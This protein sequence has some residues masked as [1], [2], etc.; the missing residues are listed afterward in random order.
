MLQKRGA[1]QTR[2]GLSACNYCW[3]KPSSRPN[4]FQSQ[5]SWSTSTRSR[6]FCNGLATQ[7][8][9]TVIASAHLCSLSS[10]TCLHSPNSSKTLVKG[11]C[12]HWS[13][14]E[15]LIDLVVLEQFFS[16]LPEGSIATIQHCYNN[17]SD[18]WSGR[19]GGKETP[20]S[21]L[22]SHSHSSSFSHHPPNPCTMEIGPFPQKPET[23][24]GRGRSMETLDSGNWFLG[25]WPVF[26]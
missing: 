1:G 7:A 6:L 12:W 24:T 23:E 14:T 18:W 11:G 19:S 16:Q 22:L 2:S 10:A 3:E 26:Q 15:E 8:N 5:T 20:F 9:S 17:W 21:L 13:G 25:K 4:S